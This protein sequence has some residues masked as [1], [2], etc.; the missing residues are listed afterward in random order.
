[1]TKIEWTE[2][3]WN[4]VVGC[5]KVSPGC[6][7]CYA[8]TMHKRLTAMGARGYEE[9]FRVVRLLDHKVDALAKRKKPT[10]YFVNSMSDM[11]HEKVDDA[12]IHQLLGVMRVH[13]QHTFQI[14]TKRA[15]AV[16]RLPQNMA[17]ECVGGGEH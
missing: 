14:L 15:G 8:A 16:A 6:K 12:T 13:K 1:M 7:N 10:M 5:T 2:K 3:T 9:P 11:F 4:P 17:A